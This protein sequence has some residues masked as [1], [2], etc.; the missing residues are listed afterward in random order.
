MMRQ[1][2]LPSWISSTDPVSMKTD[3]Q[4]G[5]QYKYTILTPNKPNIT[6]YNAKNNEAIKKQ[7]S[8]V[9]SHVAHRFVPI[10]VTSNLWIIPSN[11]WILGSAM[12][13]ICPDKATNTV[14]LQEP[15]Q[16]LRL[17]PACSAPSRYFHLPPHYEDHS[18]ITNVSLDTT[19]INTIYFS[20][21]D[22]IIWP[23]FSS[24]WTP[25]HLQ[26]LANVPYMPVT[27]LQ[28]YDQH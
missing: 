16:I 26:R 3:K 18:I 11:L 15:F 23:Y 22:F 27:A 28:R 2:Q 10:A 7:C 9:I 24:N 1:K 21:L 4:T 12:T 17:S 20:T 6:W 8:L 5:L 25:S 13:I 14:P 19:N